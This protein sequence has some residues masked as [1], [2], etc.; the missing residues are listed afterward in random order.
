ML[1]EQMISLSHQQDVTQNN[2][3]SFIPAMTKLW[4]ELPNSIV[5]SQEL[6]NFEIG[7]NNFFRR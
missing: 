7:A 3:K 4:N 1:Y 5:E 2:I 6:Q